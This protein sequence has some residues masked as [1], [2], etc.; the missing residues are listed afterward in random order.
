MKVYRKG[1][2]IIANEDK[3]CKCKTCGGQCEDEVED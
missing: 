3:W 2:E 1:L